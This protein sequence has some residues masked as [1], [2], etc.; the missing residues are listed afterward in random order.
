MW[1]HVNCYAWEIKVPVWGVVYFF[2][3]LPLALNVIY[4]CT[5]YE[6]S[7]YFTGTPH[8]STIQLM[9]MVVSLNTKLPAKRFP[10]SKHIATL[11]HTSH[12]GQPS[13]NCFASRQNVP[14]E[15]AGPLSSV[16]HI[17][18]RTDGQTLQAEIMDRCN[19]CDANTTMRVLRRKI[20][21]MW[22]PQVWITFTC[23]QGNRDKSH[24]N[25][26]Q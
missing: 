11:V 14:R 21:L 9:S 20:T 15:K 6:D 16:T 22:H 26:K 2:S 5:L 19:W 24:Y 17:A 4:F 23:C 18:D 7:N 13:Q 12:A 1:I 25:Y 10:F 8:K 3:Y